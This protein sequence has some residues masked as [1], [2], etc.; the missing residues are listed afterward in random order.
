MKLVF[1]FL[2]RSTIQ[3]SSH[4]R[5]SV[6]RMLRSFVPLLLMLTTTDFDSA[7]G[8]PLESDTTD[9]EDLTHDDAAGGGASADETDEPHHGAKKSGGTSGRRSAGGSSA[10]G[11]H[12]HGGVHPSDLR[13]KLLKTAQEKASKA[14]KS[15]SASASRAVSPAGSDDEHSKR[16]HAR[17][18]SPSPTPKKKKGSRA[19]E[20]EDIHRVE[21]EE[22]VK[23]MPV[24]YDTNTGSD[25][26]DG[27]DVDAQEDVV[28]R[29]AKH[30]LIDTK[31][32]F[33]N[34][35]F[36]ALIRLLQV[37]PHISL[38]YLYMLIIV[39]AAVLPI[40]SVQGNWTEARY[41]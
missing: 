35:T 8:P 20:K 18:A 7:F 13:K 26:K 3:Y 31:P 5:R 14:A 10:S 33:M 34:T 29:L 1:S 23:L 4:E 9:N 11:S 12:G 22:W 15:G 39:S 36:Y 40:T 16:S 6:E 37:S 41:S 17:G 38:T 30:G 19:K 28:E 25:A 2:D 21:W 27:M 32:F 24:A